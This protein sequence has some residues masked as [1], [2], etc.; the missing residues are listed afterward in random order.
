[1]TPPIAAV[2]F[3]VG[4]PLST[5]V[6]HERRVEGDIAVALAAEG[7]AVTAVD[8]ARASDVAVT[9]YAGDAYAAM[10]WWLAGRHRDRAARVF[11]R[12][13]EL[14]VVRP[15]MFELRPGIDALL[16][17]LHARGLRL[18]L[19]ANQPTAM[20][21]ELDAAGIGQ[22]FDH[23]QMSGHHG[24]RKPDPRVFIAACAGLGVRPEHC[25]M[26]RDRIDNDIA[27]AKA[28]GMRAVLFRT[29][30]HIA[31]QPRS[32]AEVPD[33]EVREVGELRRAL[34]RLID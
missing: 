2:L 1:M 11:R 28:L 29:G 3:D 6:E 30:R 31:Q 5:E 9:S 21:A 4:G 10:I 14:A 32:H 20:L 24:Y 16:A 23:R 22:Y 26:V 34:G 12:F 27:P 19:A 25:V 18:G 7:V 13:Q 15:P 17:E 33:A 8:L